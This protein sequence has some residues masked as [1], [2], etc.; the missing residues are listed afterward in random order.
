ML[1][2][3]LLFLPGEIT[4]LQQAV[5]QPR[6]NPDLAAIQRTVREK[7]VRSLNREGYTRREIMRLTGLSRHTINR[8]LNSIPGASSKTLGR[9][10][11]VPRWQA[12]SLA[13]TQ[14]TIWA[15]S[16]TVPVACSARLV[17]L[18]PVEVRFLA[19][20]LAELN[21]FHTDPLIRYL[22]NYFNYLVDSAAT[23][24]VKEVVQ[25][26]ARLLYG[27]NSE[28]Y[29]Q[30]LDVTRRGV[31]YRTKIASGVMHLVEPDASRR[32]FDTCHCFRR[33]V[34]YLGRNSWAVKQTEPEV[35]PPISLAKLLPP[36]RKDAAEHR[37]T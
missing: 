19:K 28:L 7:L 17:V 27:R 33:E 32:H 8:R 26:W 4:R 5:S 10:G 11:L 6:D 20:V 9:N 3:S 36:A 25:H 29:R 16:W 23:V 37:S 18:N 30:Y 35:I 15:W 12:F 21:Q 31:F 34:L 2:L 1:Y 14:L 22:G 24:P 13:M